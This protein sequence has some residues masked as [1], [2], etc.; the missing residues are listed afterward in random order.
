MP[1]WKI[2]WENSMIKKHPIWTVI[3]IFIIVLILDIQVI[4]SFFSAWQRSE[5]LDLVAA[6]LIAVTLY[7]QSKSVEKTARME[8]A[9]V[10]TEA[11]SHAE[12][13][14]AI[15]YFLKVFPHLTDEEGNDR[16]E[17]IDLIQ[18][19][20]E[21]KRY[22]Y[23][24]LTTLHHAERLYKTEK[25]DKTL[26]TSLITPD[27]VEVALCLYKLDGFV[28]GV[29]K[30][31]YEM[32]YKVF[33]DI[34]TSYLEPYWYALS[35]KTSIDDKQV[36]KTRLVLKNLQAWDKKWGDDVDR[37]LTEKDLILL[38]RLEEKVE[39]GDVVKELN[40]LIER[41][42]AYRRETKPLKKPEAFAELYFFRGN[43]KYRL[44]QYQGAIDD[45]TKAIEFNPQDSFVFYN[46]GG[47][48]DALGNP[49]EA[50]DD[51]TKALE[52]NPQY[53]DAYYN[54]GNAK[55]VLNDYNGAIE[56]YNKAIE[57]NPQYADAYYNRG[58]TYKKMGK[59]AEADKDFAEYERLTEGK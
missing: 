14:D 56:D 27:L 43:T 52:L 33:E 26:F 22:H 12:M 59:Q 2:I 31:V 15:D 29:D 28:H 13:F 48:K 50:I 57:L 45:Y 10:L 58:V 1:S 18:N 7:L 23:R 8:M 11:F 40:K 53:A 47:A 9:K 3:V 20:P 37:L 24:L 42:E 4:T 36:K 6:I 5:W 51:Y 25:A 44:K 39:A 35:N 34:R 41:F 54:R 32:V 46:R 21:T 17:Y 38:D 49:Q 55:D 19:A 16:K 30:P